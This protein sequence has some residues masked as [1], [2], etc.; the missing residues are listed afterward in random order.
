M[1]ILLMRLLPFDGE[2]IKS[3]PFSIVPRTDE[4]IQHYQSNGEYS[5]S[6]SYNLFLED[7]INQITPLSTLMNR[8]WSS[9]W[10]L[11]I[12]P[13]I[14]LF[15]WRVINDVLPTWALLIWRK[16]N[17]SSGCGRCETLESISYVLFSCIGVWKMVD[18][19]ELVKLSLHSDAREVV[20]GILS[21]GY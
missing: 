14:K 5:I 6:S 15:I 13:K 16:M 7:Q 10:H 17:I 9:L 4:I 2:L 8:W 11:K 3:I 21:R 19:W 18:L 20:I 12:P 1:I